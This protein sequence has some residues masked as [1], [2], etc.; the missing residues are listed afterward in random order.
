MAAVSCS[1]VIG[2]QIGRSAAVKPNCLNLLVERD[3]RIADEVGEDDVGAAAGDVVDDGREL[4][5]S[6]RRI[7]LADILAAMLLEQRL[8]LAV[9]LL[10]IDVVR[11]D[12]VELLAA[13]SL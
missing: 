5:V 7:F 2:V 1:V 4:G 13:E 8:H 9:R 6:E 3:D 11:A 12:H 10:R